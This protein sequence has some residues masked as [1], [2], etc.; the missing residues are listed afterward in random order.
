MKTK[1]R[2][3]AADGT[4]PDTLQVE[5]YETVQRHCKCNWRLMRL[6]L[7]LFLSPPPS[8]SLREGAQTYSHISCYRF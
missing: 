8:H 3:A 1:W 7:I 2:P 6:Q 4:F 5:F